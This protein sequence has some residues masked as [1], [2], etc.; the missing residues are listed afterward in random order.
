V[1]TERGKR[2]TDFPSAA[3]CEL[4][5][6]FCPFCPGNEK[7]TPPEIFALRND[8]TPADTP[9]W[10]I[11]VV[12]NKYP[13]LHI[14][15][16]LHKR[17]HGI[18]DIMNGIGAHEVFI[19]TPD[20]CNTISTLS[21]ENVR[22]LIWCYRERI[23]DLSKDRRLQYILI[24]RNSGDAAGASLEHPHSQLIA[25]PSI[26]KRIMEEIRGTKAYYDFKDRC[27]FCDM[28]DEE[29]DVKER[30]VMENEHFV[31]FVPFAAR[32]PFET[33]ILPKKHWISFENLGDD[34]ILP[35]A[36]ALQETIQRLDKGLSFPP[37][38]F[39]IHTSPVNVTADASYHWHV[40][41]IPRLTKVAGFEWGSGFYINPM[42][43]E[44]AAAELQ[45][46]EV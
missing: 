15:G 6:K 42:P 33:W 3:P 34:I 41:I 14:E 19:E 1:S 32:F 21:R 9:G 8:N 7:S 30:I 37:Y 5:S 36:H 43:P 31:S 28:V 12:S 29:L 27:V 13:A 11:R 38:N 40:E 25:T 39:L 26:P 44:Q 18:Y 2:P 10:R 35:F 4:K 22:E 20:H 17:A 16:D 46:V 24:F 45:S 23:R